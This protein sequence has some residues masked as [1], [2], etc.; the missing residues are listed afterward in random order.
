[1]AEA[2]EDLLMSLF[3]EASE[4]QCGTEQIILVRD[5]AA[6][7]KLLADRPTLQGKLLTVREAK[8]LEFNDVLLYNFFG[9]SPL[10]VTDWRTLGAYLQKQIHIWENEGVPRE[11]V[12]R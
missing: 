2:S 5:D 7:K 8:G 12:S 11:A 10:S 4:P 1:L 3:K 9:D 6:K